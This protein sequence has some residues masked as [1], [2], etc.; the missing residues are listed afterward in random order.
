M[1]T[2]TCTRRTS[3]IRRRGPRSPRRSSAFT[4][5]SPAVGS[6]AHR[7]LRFRSRTHPEDGKNK[8]GIQMKDYLAGGDRMTRFLIGSACLV[9]LLA[10]LKAVA[11]ILDIVLLALFLAVTVTPFQDFLLRKNLRPALAVTVPL[12]VILVSGSLIIYLFAGTVSKLIERL[13]A[14]GDRLMV[15][16][17]A[18]KEFCVSRGVDPARVM[19][20]GA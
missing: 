19:P 12:L 8:K 4:A 17:D 11:P 7:Q 14:Y 13:P 2:G 9:I 20:S 3:N 10:G 16:I 6:T 18:L 15:V 1:P 5:L